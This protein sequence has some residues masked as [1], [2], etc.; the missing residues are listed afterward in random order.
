[1]PSPNLWNVRQPSLGQTIADMNFLSSPQVGG[2]AARRVTRNNSY[3]FNSLTY[4][5][6][7]KIFVR[8]FCLRFLSRQKSQNWT[9]N[10]LW[11]PPNI[12]KICSLKST[13]LFQRFMWGIVGTDCDKIKRRQQPGVV[14]RIIINL[15]PCKLQLIYLCYDSTVCGVVSLG[16][17]N[18]HG[19]RHQI[20][21]SVLL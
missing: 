1:M 17:Q 15:L 5:G 11:P 18:V 20:A 21:F 4:R 12:L 13:H 16:V 7:P 9:W 8:L 19:L 6:P 2:R 3:F 14:S 10:A